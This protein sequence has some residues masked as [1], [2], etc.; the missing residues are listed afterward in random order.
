MTAAGLRSAQAAI[1]G[2]RS[3]VE[4][5]DEARHAEENAADLIDA[6]EGAQSALRSLVGVATVSDNALIREARAR[7]LIELDEA[8]SL[9]EFGAAADRARD[10]TYTPNAGDLS[11]ARAGFQ[12]LE[13]ALGRAPLVSSRPAAPRPGS[14]QVPPAVENPVAVV[15]PAGSRRS[16]WLARGVVI[17]AGIVVVAV[18]AY[19]VIELELRNG[20]TQ[21][22]VA[23]YTRGDRAT[24]KQE[25]TA[26]ANQD[27]KAALPHVYLGRIARDEGD[28]VTAGRELNT[29]IALEPSNELALREMGAHLFALGNLDLAR[30]FYVRAVTI[31]PTD[32]TALGYLACTL[33][34]LGRVEEGQRFALRAGTGDWSACVDAAQPAPGATRLPPR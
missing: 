17:A 9:V 4:R 31:D 12:L 26:L 10:A 2:A 6:W 27:S 1:D 19:Y 32:R 22:G 8:H 13:S 7:N 3:A 18:V 16:N 33:A 11:A 30:R 14:S 23:A 21:R 29:A 24:A 28:P 5:L 20:H 34:R 25:F 15:P